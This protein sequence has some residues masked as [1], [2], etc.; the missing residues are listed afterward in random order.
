MTRPDMISYFNPD[1][2][3]SILVP[4]EWKGQMV[5]EA[6][7]RLLGW[8][9]P[10]Y[11][12]YRPTMSY[13]Y[14]RPQGYGADWLESIIVQ[15]EREMRRDYNQFKLERECRFMLSSGAPTYVRWFIW[16][17]SDSGLRFAQL[18]SFVRASKMSMYLIN[19][20]T[21]EPLKNGHMPIFEA[22]LKS[23]R[24]IP[25]LQSGETR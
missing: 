8:P 24:I 17:D 6:Q 22:I 5:N 16:Q 18:Q 19:A 13:L 7:L 25:P 4:S 23:T 10:R 2:H 20:A 9:E 3:L 11:H 15:S 14:A 21:L 1:L 12:D